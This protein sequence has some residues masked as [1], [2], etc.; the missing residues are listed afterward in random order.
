MTKLHNYEFPKLVFKPETDYIEMDKPLIAIYPI[1]D[2]MDL[3]Y[4]ISLTKFG[5]IILID[6]IFGIRIKVNGGLEEAKELAQQRF[7]YDITQIL[8][9]V[10]IEVGE[11]DE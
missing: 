1:T 5:S 10:G 11:T 6:N 8:N 9:H 7:E 2:C 4:V 3:D